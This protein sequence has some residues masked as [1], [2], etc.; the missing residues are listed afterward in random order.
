MHIP[1]GFLSVPVLLGLG[2]LSAG[3][4]GLAARW[5]A[6]DLEDRQIPLMGVSGAFVFAAQM[7]NVPVGIGTSG[8]LLGGALLAALLG[9]HLAALVMVCV[10]AVQ[11]LLFQDGGLT[12]LGANA[13][14]MAV[15]G[16]YVAWAVLAVGR[17]FRAEWVAL[18]AAG[19]ASV[20]AGALLAAVE[21]AV[22]GTVPLWPALVAMGTLHAVIG[23]GEGLLTVLVVRFL[24][25]VRP[26][27][28]EV[29]R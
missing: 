6:R 23:V 11:C 3:G 21:L 19:W 16:P 20:V 9:P 2:A 1:D 12:A 29:G 27:L 18:F 10:V 4:I 26:E 17:R 25:R 24:A 8:H 7:V 22:S 13:F 5:G 14:N 28:V 15:V